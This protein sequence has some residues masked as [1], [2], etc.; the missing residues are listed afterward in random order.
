MIDLTVKNRLHFN[1]AAIPFLGNRIGKVTEIGM[2]SKG[3]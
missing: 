2:Y 3:T 1:R